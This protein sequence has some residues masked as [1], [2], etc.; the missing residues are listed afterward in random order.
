MRTL[1][2]SFILLCVWSLSLAQDPARFVYDKDLPDN[3][4]YAGNRNSLRAL[5]PDK[6]VA[7]F[8]AN[9]IRNRS[10]DVDFDYHQDPNFY[11]FTG[12]TEP[13]SMLFIFKEQVEVNG[14]KTNEM[15]FVQS[16]DPK[17]EQWDGR[18]FGIDGVKSI[19][20]FNQ[21]YLNTEFPIEGFD[22]KQFEK[23]LIIGIPEGMTDKKSNKAE[24]YDMVE[25][26][27]YA[28]GFP[29]QRVNTSLL[30]DYMHDLRGIKQPIE[31]ALMR[32]AI[33]IT[34]DA[35][36]ELMKNQ[37][38]GM[39]EYESQAI[40][41]YVFKKGGA[42]HPGFPS[43]LGSGENSCI[44]HYKNGRR[45][46][47]PNDLL[48]VDVGAEYHGYTADVTRTFPVNGKFS[49]DQRKI[50]ELVLK[51][52]EAG[53]K[54]LKP[55][56]SF[57]EPNR[58]A[59]DIIAQGLLDLGVLKDKDDVRTYF[60]HG[61]SHHLGLDVHDMGRKSDLKAGMVITV[62]PG[63]YIAEGSDC[64]PKWWNIGVRIEDDILITPTGYENLSI[65][66]PRSIVEIEALMQ[67]I[68]INQKGK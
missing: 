57:Y 50:Y 54:A 6:S 23:V 15:I 10:N 26:F 14:S 36:I 29:G 33:N 12:F 3:S 2:T 24:L 56:V 59:I 16:R 7:F 51:A 64:D 62:E 43:I 40:I 5:M 18:R 11:Y 13:N 65:A 17:T 49:P 41:E 22:L 44:L 66:A 9:P 53:I 30:K 61:T 46:T 27:K 68:N 63:I 28:A 48:V 37:K 47:G 45:E 58:I 42:K 19:L 39:N 35:Q 34:V 25:Q 55:G 32:K 20:G 31:I 21:V 52:Q 8:F 67:K 38:P 1:I 60:M 4:F